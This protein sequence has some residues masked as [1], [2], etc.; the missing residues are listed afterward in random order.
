M[1]FLSPL[2]VESWNGIMM[3]WWVALAENLG[4]WAIRSHVR[5]S[6]SISLKQ[7]CHLHF[8]RPAKTSHHF[9]AHFKNHFCRSRTA[10]KHE[11]R[12]FVVCP[13]KTSPGARWS[14]ERALVPVGGIRL[15]LFS[16]VSLADSVI[17][18]STF[19]IGRY[20]MCVGWEFPNFLSF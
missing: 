1:L 20:K 10:T 9:T 17:S 18:I 15:L 6:I 3:T 8:W 4:P 11:Q 5:I 16:I 14:S 7:W 13:W 2:V 12:W 19:H